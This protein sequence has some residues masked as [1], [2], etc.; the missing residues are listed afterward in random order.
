MVNN[1]TIL[2]VLDV[3]TDELAEFIAASLMAGIQLPSPNPNQPIDVINSVFPLLPALANRSI[4]A[5]ELYV[6]CMGA[7]PRATKLAGD[8]MNTA[9]L[10]AKID[11]L[12]RTI[13][14]IEA[15]RETAIS[16]KS[17]MQDKSQFAL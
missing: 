16:M 9:S 13:Q 4:F 6:R 15:C 10:N 17:G 3:T 12:Y 2:N 8:V 11:M 1:I 5:T 7:K 14:T